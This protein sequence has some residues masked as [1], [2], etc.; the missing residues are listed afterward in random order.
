MK[1]KL[2]FFYNGFIVVLTSVLIVACSMASTFALSP[3]SQANYDMYIAPF[4]IAEP[5]SPYFILHCAKGNLAIIFNE[6]LA[7]LAIPPATSTARNAALSIQV[8]RATYDSHTDGNGFWQ[9]VFENVSRDNSGPVSATFNITVACTSVS[10][11]TNPWVRNYQRTLSIS[12]SSG[13]TYQLT[14][15]TFYDS[16]N[17]SLGALQY[18]EC[19][20]GFYNGD[21]AM[22]NRTSGFFATSNYCNVYAYDY[23]GGST[24]YTFN[25]PTV[26]GSTVLNGLLSSSVS[27]IQSS[28][29]SGTYKQSLNPYNTDSQQTVINSESDLLSQATQY[30]PNFDINLNDFN[31][32]GIFN[33]MTNI[34]QS[35]QLVFSAFGIILTI[36]LAKFALGRG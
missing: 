1:N 33:Y 26:W 31:P 8:T 32:S 4:P 22:V 23:Y 25:F 27:A 6:G 9:V 24:K 20:G 2:Y 11:N 10:K 5:N 16:L 34:L 12:S 15:S 21:T 14:S 3:N 17:Y 18:I 19:H 7:D 13:S 36:A 30:E 35:N 28:V 29:S